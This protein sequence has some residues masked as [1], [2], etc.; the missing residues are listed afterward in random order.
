MRLL[1]LFSCLCL[2]SLSQQQP[3]GE[4]KHGDP[5]LDEYLRQ[6]LEMLRGWM[7]GGYPDLG[8]PV[9]DPFDVPK[10]EIPHIE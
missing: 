6:I 7:A 2:F 4:P 1:Y 9:L 10:F 3:V 5:A 8:I